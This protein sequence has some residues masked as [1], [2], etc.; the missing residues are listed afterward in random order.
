[1]HLYG[2]RMIKMTQIRKSFS[3]FF[4]K[5]TQVWALATPMGKAYDSDL[6]I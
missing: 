4:V 5:P 1:M 2:D 3:I 6:N